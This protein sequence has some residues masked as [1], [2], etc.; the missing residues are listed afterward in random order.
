MKK[1][2]LCAALLICLICTVFISAPVF[3]A[4]SMS[5]NKTQFTPNEEVQIT[6]AGLSDEQIDDGAYIA[7]G[8]KGIRPENADFHVYVSDL[9]ANNV[10][11]FDAPYGFGEYEAFLMDYD[12]ASVYDK[13]E[14]SVGGS[15]AKEGDITLSK[16]E[17][18]LN[19]PMSV[20]VKGLTDGQVESGAWL[21]I[22]KWD[23]KLENTYHN[24]Y[25]ADL[26]ANNTYEFTAPEKFGKYEVRVFS[27][28]NAEPEAGFFGKAEF[29]VVSSKAKEGDIVLSKTSVNP[30]EKM[31]V[32]VNGIS[33]GEI[34]AGAW[35]G[36]APANEKLE[37]TY[38][39]AYISDLPVG[40]KYEFTAPSKPGTYEVRVF[41][42]YGLEDDEFE[43]GRFG[44]VQFTVG[45]SPVPSEELPAG[46]EGLS[47]WAATEVNQAIS[48]DLVTDKVLI[49][50]P[51]D[52]TREEFCE[53]AVLLYEKMTGNKAE[54]VAVNP[55]TDT[56]NPEILKAYNL[57]IVNGIS[58]DKFA[59]A[60]KVTRQEISVMLLRTLKAAMPDITATAEF[61]TKFQD[62]S[63]IASWAL[64]AV[65]FMN[66]NDIVKGSTV[67]GVTYIL[68]KGNTTKE[69]AILLILR[70]YNAF[71]KI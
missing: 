23:E 52:I 50:F 44:S 4:A 53:L 62:E 71:Y 8:K 68:P 20:T 5:I 67:N 22:S 48:E 65:R 24:T 37:N 39:N 3:A 12:T 34:D 27:D 9:P 35:L 58:E 16:S 18:K 41:C 10:Y 36:I 63:E 15:K 42:A 31:S 38:H 2:L 60:N 40:N 33:K 6:V 17:A 11:E 32:T 64:E 46:H 47:G 19:E 25:I 55:F 70:T 57:K 1:R 69:Q 66:A 45:G 51:E 49:E 54:P 13:I 56:K 26:P 14:F 7:I 28:Y 29:L 61:K 21:G 59:P 30:E 43:Y